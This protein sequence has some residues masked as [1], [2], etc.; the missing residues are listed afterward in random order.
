MY[1][2]YCF[3]PVESSA[4]N[5]NMPNKKT[6]TLFIIYGFIVSSCLFI[7]VFGWSE[8]K[9]CISYSTMYVWSVAFIDNIQ[10]FTSYIL[11]A[12]Q[13]FAWHLITSRVL[14]VFHRH[15]MDQLRLNDSESFVGA[16]NSNLHCRIALYDL[17]D[18][19]PIYR[20]FQQYC[21]HRYG[22]AQCIVAP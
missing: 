16:L 22:N 20:T 4:G 11:I 13:L 18:R 12:A 8:C 7:F 3:N 9:I 17:H 14:C 10:N 1:N 19:Q 6:T 15:N 5:V 2:N 21:T